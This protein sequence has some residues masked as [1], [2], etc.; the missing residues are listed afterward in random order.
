M[1]I[2]DDVD[3]GLAALALSQVLQLAG[4]MQWCVRQTAELENQMTSTER[5][6][7]YTKLPS[8]HPRVADGA[9]AAPKQWPKN[10]KV[11]RHLCLVWVLYCHSHCHV[12]HERKRNV[13]INML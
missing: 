12:Q 8:D 1:A 13:L 7:E 6:L 2:K 4:L 5:L 11:S 10:G 9:A 3:P